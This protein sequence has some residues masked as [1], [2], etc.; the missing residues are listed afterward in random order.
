MNIIKWIFSRKYRKELRDRKVDEQFY[1]FITI[2]GLRLWN[3]GQLC[4]VLFEG[5]CACGAM[6]D[7]SELPER[8]NR[9]G[10]S[11]VEGGWDVVA[12]TCNVFDVPIPADIEKAATKLLEKE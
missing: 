10:C 5:P 6:H 2:T 4:D 3:G 11:N 9:R 7:R 8:I 12:V 1:S